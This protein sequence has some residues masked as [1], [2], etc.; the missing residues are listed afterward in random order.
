MYKYEANHFLKGAHTITLP[1]NRSII[2]FAATAV[3]NENEDVQSLQPLYD[4]FE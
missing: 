1:N 2:I 4:N 3:R